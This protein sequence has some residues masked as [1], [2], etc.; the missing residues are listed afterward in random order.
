MYATIATVSAVSTV[1]AMYLGLTLVRAYDLRF[2][3]FCL[4]ILLCLAVAMWAVAKMDDI[5][6]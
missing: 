1:P 2:E 6:R 5:S 4:P 3:L